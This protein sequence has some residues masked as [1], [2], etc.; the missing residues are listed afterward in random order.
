MKFIAHLSR[1]N[2]QIIHNDAHLCLYLIYNDVYKGA[3]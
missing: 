2:A 3:S 1:E